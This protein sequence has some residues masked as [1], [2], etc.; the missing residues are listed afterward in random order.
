MLDRPTDLI[1]LSAAADLLPRPRP[2]I[3]T[4]VRTVLRW[5]MDGKLQGWRLA[6]RWYVS[7]AD[8]VAMA[9]PFHAPPAITSR[10]DIRRRREKAAQ[11]LRDA[12]IT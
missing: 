10:G 11:V 3:K 7:R 1:P 4:H 12:R 6:G 5:I 2:G 8:L 9:T